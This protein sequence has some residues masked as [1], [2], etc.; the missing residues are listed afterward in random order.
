MEVWIY[1]G[2]EIDFGYHLSYSVPNCGD[3]QYS[4]PSTLLFY[5]YRFYWRWKVTARGDSIPNLVEIVVKIGF[6]FFQ[7]YLVYSFCPSVLFHFLEC[8]QYYFL[9]IS[10][11]LILSVGSFLVSVHSSSLSVVCTELV[12]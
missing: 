7:A 5:L 6:E 12:D 11:D 10:Y 1:Q 2:I 3:S 4:L 8:F 9:G